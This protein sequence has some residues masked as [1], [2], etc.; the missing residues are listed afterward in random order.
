MTRRVWNMLRT[1]H[2]VDG[3]VLT[4]KNCTPAPGVH[5]SLFLVLSNDC[6]CAPSVLS[7]VKH[8]PEENHA[9][10]TLTGGRKL[11]LCRRRQSD[12]S[13]N[14]E[15]QILTDKHANSASAYGM[16]ISMLKRKVM[17]IITGSAKA[18]IR[19]NVYSWKRCT[20]WSTWT[21]S[22]QRMS[23][24]HCS[25]SGD[26][27]TQSALGVSDTRS[28]CIHTKIRFH[29]C[30]SHHVVG[31]GDM[32]TVH[33]IGAVDPGTSVVLLQGARYE[34]LLLHP[35]HLFVGCPWVLL[36]SREEVGGIWTCRRTWHLAKDG[37]SMISRRL[38]MPGHTEERLGD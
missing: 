1:F 15:L 14:R 23:Q 9:Q 4:I 36:P 33:G 29:G 25:N 34:Q 32:D 18:E 21:Q 17:V 7:A 5:C 22:F 31:L 38:T 26:G 8:L 12:V 37:F 2:V 24:D 30:C 35:S 11:R 28:I 27:Q 10:W 19:I 20:L 13:S 3:L 6:R 16:E